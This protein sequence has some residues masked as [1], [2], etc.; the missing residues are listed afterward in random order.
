MKAKVTLLHVAVVSLVVGIAVA[1]LGFRGIVG[2][3]PQPPRG[4]QRVGS[5]T[6]K[7]GDA[8]LMDINNV[9]LPMDRAGVLANVTI[10]N[11]GEG[12]F[13]GVGFLF[14]G[15]F[16]MTGKNPDGTMWAN[17]Q[18]TASRIQDYGPGRAIRT[19]NDDPQ[20]YVVDGDSEPFGADWQAWADAVAMGADFYDGDGDGQYN[21]ID[22]NGN[23]R[24]DPNEDRPDLLGDLTAWCIY[25]DNIPSAQ[26]RFSEVPPRGIDIQQSVFGFRSAGLLGNMLF[27][28]Y[29]IIN[30]GRYEQQYDSVFFG[31]WADADLGGSGGYTDDL[32]GCDTSL[33]AGF[34]WNDGPDPV[35]GGNPPC[36]LID[37]FQGPVQYLPGVTFIDANGNGVYDPGEVALDTAYNVRG[38]VLGVDTIPGARNLGLHS[39]VNYVQS[40]PDRGDPN[41][42]FEARNYLTGRLRLGGALDPC[43]DAFGQVF[44]MNCTEVNPTFWYSGDPTVDPG[45]GWIYTTPDDMRQMQNTGPFALKA[46]EPVDIVV[47]YI[48][49]RGSDARNSVGVAKNIS[50]FAQFIYDRN[51]ET[52]PPPPPARPLIRT[53]ENTIELIWPTHEQFNYNPVSSAY[54]VLFGGFEVR[55]YNSRSTAAV[56]GGRVNARVIARYDVADSINNVLLEHANGERTTL[57]EK[58]I[59][60]N[61]DTHAVE[62]IGRIRLV[63]TTDPFT[64]QNLIKGRPYFISIT[65][66]GLNRPAL[67]RLQSGGTS[68][69]L[70]SA[71]SFITY[72]ENVPV[73]LNNGIVPGIHFNNPYR[74]EEPAR[75]EA[76]IAEGAV[77]FDEIHRDST[78]GHEY[79]VGFFKDLASPSYSMYWRL[80]DA[81]LNTVKLDSQK[82]YIASD[83]YAVRLIDGLRIRVVNVVAAFRTPTYSATPWYT[84]NP[85]VFYTG[86]DL[87]DFTSTFQLGS[88]RSNL[89]SVEKMRRV[90]VRFGPSQKAYR[91]VNGPGLQTT[92]YQYAAGQQAADSTLPNFRRGYVDVPFQVWIA[93]DRIGET[94][95]V[96]C[97]FFEDRRSGAPDGI[98]NPGTNVDGSQTSSREVI[99]VYDTDYSP[100]TNIVYTGGVYNNFTRWANGHAGW[101]VPAQWAGVVQLS[102]ADSARA[103]D[104]W[105]SAMYVIPLQRRIDEDTGDTLFY[106]PGEVLTIPIAYP[107]TPQDVFTYTASPP[108]GAVSTERRQQQFDRVTVYPNPLFAYNPATSYSSTLGADEPFV[109][110]SNLPEDVTIRI[111]SLS[112]ILLRTLTTSNKAYGATSPFLNWDLKNES[113]LRVASGMYLA[114]VSSPGIGEKILKFAVILPQKQIQKF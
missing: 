100:D 13:D 42:S 31:V 24:W 67:V 12:V 92:V 81:T 71:Q 80:V 77:Y 110:F 43:T 54:D 68:N 25:T 59:Q 34:T 19:P 108:G 70:L 114:I 66:Y 94:R 102:P 3:G 7:V 50:T 109:T 89:M 22:L 101:A 15:G 62:G 41:N 69:F 85:G 17:G 45:Y 98:W 52:A 107:F 65:G 91:Y 26:R 16:L 11:I 21:P 2:G 53:T 74:I 88:R 60:L 9:K 37:F 73:I 49:G 39:F 20:I 28:R 93:D 76:G 90:E 78:T 57:F 47:A 106:R 27:I 104:P 86:T 95:Q 113:G 84:I 14:S 111:Y 97:G 99:I 10:G 35:Y 83:N 18:A 82:T 6:G 55:M 103:A 51:F 44:G 40:N 63:I 5:V 8:Y 32:V 4:L 30:S 56:E 75:R 23:G 96:N 36:F 64:G 48:V 105:L 112:G 29:R 61:A 33:N 58:G 72:T 46:G 87:P 38:Q 1:S 79:R